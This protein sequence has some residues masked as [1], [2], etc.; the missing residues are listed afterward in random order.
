[1]RLMPYLVKNGAGTWC[2]QKAV[3][4]RLQRTVAALKK[5]QK[6]RQKFVRTSLGTKDKRVAMSC[7]RFDG[8][9]D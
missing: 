2:V 4:E 8:H 9:R 3:P 7:C 6:E 1:M 5:S